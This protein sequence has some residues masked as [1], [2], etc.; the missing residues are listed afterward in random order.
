[1]SLK[2]AEIMSMNGNNF[3]GTITPTE[4]RKKIFEEVLGLTQDDLVGITIGY[5]RGRIITY[6]LKQQRDIDQLFN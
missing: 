1:M 5:N 4:A 2:T 3:T 6:K